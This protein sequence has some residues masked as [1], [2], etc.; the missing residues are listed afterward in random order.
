MK[1]R[2]STTSRLNDWAASILVGW[3]LPTNEQGGNSMVDDARPTK[4]P[5]GWS[6]A[7]CIAHA[8]NRG[9]LTIG[10]W[11]ACFLFWRE[12]MCPGPLQLAQEQ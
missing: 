2:S 6:F 10:S 11:A 7:Q 12:T 3:A 4:A 1:K 9:R 5:E 8:A